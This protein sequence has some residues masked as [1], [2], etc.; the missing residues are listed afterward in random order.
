MAID[1]LH[2]AVVDL[3]PEFFASFSIGID[4]STP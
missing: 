1:Y 3:N 2:L 4:V